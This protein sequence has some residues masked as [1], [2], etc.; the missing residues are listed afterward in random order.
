MLKIKVKNE[1]REGNCV[2]YACHRDV[3]GVGHIVYSVLRESGKSRSAYGTPCAF[4]YTLVIESERELC[5]LPDVAREC[6]AALA[7]CTR[8]ADGGVL[9]AHAEDVYVELCFA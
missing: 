5:R 2:I 7:L 1:G 3:S 4:F 8:F 6:D 9:P